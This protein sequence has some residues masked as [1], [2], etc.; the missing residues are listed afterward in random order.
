MKIIAIGG[1]PATGKSTL[2]RRVLVALGPG[3]P[4]RVGLVRGT[5]HRR[6]VVLGLYPYKETFG[7][8]D[9]L[10]MAVQPDALRFLSANAGKRLVV[11]FEGDRLFN[12]SFLTAALRLAPESRL[13]LLT[14]P[15]GALSERHRRRADS[16]SDAFLKGRATK[17]RNLAAALPLCAMRNA[18]AVD[19]DAVLA[20]VLSELPS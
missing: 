12:L 5:R 3:A 16:Q 8:T 2:M 4:F 1:E 15:P 6:A 9:R 17:Y 7:G 11:L 10:S 19:G 14:A 13:F 18:D 20:A